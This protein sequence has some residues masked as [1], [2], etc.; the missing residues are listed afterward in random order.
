MFEEG[1]TG[2]SLYIVTEGSVGVMK[3]DRMVAVVGVRECFGEMAILSGETRSA[4]IRSL[5]PTRALVLRRTQFQALIEHHPR[6]AFPIFEMLS[7]RLRKA[8][9]LLRDSR[10]A[11]H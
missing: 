7:Q 8:T 10:E 5:E 11:I 2:E 1:T 3:G 4:T 6:I 9:D